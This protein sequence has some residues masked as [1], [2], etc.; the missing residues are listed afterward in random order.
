MQK[1]RNSSILKIICY[2]LIPFLVA[3]ILLSMIYISMKD[4]FGYLKNGKA[5]YIQTDNF[6]Y[7]YLSNIIYE[8]RSIKN[9]NSGLVGYTGYNYE[10]ID[11]NIYYNRYDYD[12]RTI[13]NYIKYVITNN[14]TNDIYT[15]IQSSNYQD[16][17]NNINSNE[18]Y[19]NY[20]NEEIDTNIEKI[21]NYNAKYMKLPLEGIQ[22]LEGY[23]VYTYIDTSAFKYSNIYSFRVMIFDMFKLNPDI[24]EI[25]IPVSVIILLLIVIYLIWSIGHAKEGKGIHLNSLDRFPYEF[26]LGI[27]FCT[28]AICI[29]VMKMVLYDL[30]LSINFM[31]SMIEIVY[32]IG[33]ISL[34]VWAVSTIKRLKAKEFWHTFLIYRI[35]KRI[36]TRLIK[37]ANSVLDK[38]TSQRKIIIFYVSFVIIS[39]I[40]SSTFFTGISF[41]MLITLWSYTLY[42]LLEY[43]K[44]LNEIKNAIKEVYNGNNN[45]CLDTE[46][47]KGTLKELAIYVND[48]ANGFSNAIE[49]SLKSER[50]KTELI[51]NVSHDIKTPLT[52]I[53]NYV[54]LIKQE[55]I[56]DSKIQEYI[57]VLDQ[58]SQ[59][60]KKLTE[61]LL[62][63]SK[64]SSGNVK[65]NIEQINLAELLK[66]VLGEFEDKFNEKKLILELNLL[67]DNT[68]IDAD[69]KYMYRIIENLFSNVAKYSMENTRVYISLINTDKEIKIE[70]K[71]VSKNKLNISSDELMQRF[72]RGDKSR[73]TEGSGLGLSIAK[74]L[75]ELQG[76][77]FAINIDGDLFKAILS[78]NNF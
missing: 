40:L 73:Y 6:G 59:R 23:S 42:K 54:D 56:Q 49:E 13:F 8:V 5:T 2:I 1:I 19:W 46:I 36:K 72:V 43:N 67:N 12:N 75:T 53:I 55:N 20:K 71:N 28:V 48:I 66:Q 76:G 15:N 44:K 32:I 21:N 38:S 26:L 37:S 60:L 65:L 7:N 17:I 50:F 9:P 24:A 29:A 10:K 58:K 51:T 33:Y 39:L 14:E 25:L 64:A 70:I 77:N 69:N 74:S 62:E 34:A 68:K 61:D 63:A 31:T 4:E 30:G 78:W 35:Y 27:T 45:V 22:S 16:T 57:K 3:T 52:S 18:I 41:F 47:L 11:D